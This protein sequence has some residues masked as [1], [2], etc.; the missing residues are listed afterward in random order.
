[1]NSSIIERQVC[2]SI[3]GVEIVSFLAPR[4]TTHVVSL[5]PA[6]RHRISGQFGH[7]QERNAQYGL[8]LR[9]HHDVREFLKLSGPDDI[10]ILLSH[11]PPEH[12]MAWSETDP[13]RDE[14]IGPPVAQ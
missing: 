12:L 11:V 1:M 6:L 9:A 7:S 14:W 3:G 10:V 5:W 2:V 4:I 8:D 13:D